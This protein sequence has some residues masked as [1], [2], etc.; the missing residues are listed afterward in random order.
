MNPATRGA[1]AYIAGS[2]ISGLRKGYV[3]D[4]S[5]GAYRRFSGSLEPGRVNIFDHDVGAYVTG[6]GAAGALSLYHYGQSSHLQLRVNGNQFT[7]YD[8]G[9]GSHF[10]GQVNGSNVSLYDY[11][12]SAYYNYVL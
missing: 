6:S 3:Y 8:Y 10:S 5:T 11:G 4:Y 2:L 9:T 7:G 1:A 12:D